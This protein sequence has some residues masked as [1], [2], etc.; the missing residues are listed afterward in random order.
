MLPTINRLLMK[1]ATS[2]SSL[3]QV[4]LG[5]VLLLITT[6]LAGSAKA[7]SI[8]YSTTGLAQANT[9]CTNPLLCGSGVYRGSRA[10]DADLSNY[11]VLY[12]GATSAVS[13]RLGLSGTGEAGSRAGVLLANAGQLLNLQALGAVRVRTYLLSDG[14]LQAQ[15]TRL[16]SPEVV[17]SALLEKDRPTQ[18]EFVAGK[19][20]NQI[21]LEIG[22]LANVSFAVKVFYAYSVPSLVQAQVAGYLSRFPMPADGLYSTAGTDTNLAGAR[23]CLNTEVNNPAAAVDN[24]LSNYASFSSLLTT[25]CPSALTVR[26][27]GRS[28]AGYYAGFVIGNGG[29]LDLSVLSGLRI[30]TWLNGVPQETA[31]GAGLLELHLLPNG[32][33]QV[34]FPTTLPFNEVTIERVGALTALDDLELYYGFGVEPRAFEG[35]TQVLSNFGNPAGQYEVESTALLC[36]GCTVT[37]PENAANSAVG[38]NSYAQIDVPLGVLGEISL[39]L[40]LNGTGQAGN[41]AGMVIGSGTG[42]LDA[43]ALD[44]YTLSTYDAAGNLLESRSGRELLSLNLLA[45]GRQELSFLTT[46]DFA[47]VQLTMTSG[48]SALNSTRVYYAFADDRTGSFPLQ[49]TAPAP[50]PVELTAFSARWVNNKAELNWAT[51]SERASSHFVVERASSRDAAFR[52]VSQVAAA[53]SSTAPQ[54][55]QLRD[56]GALALNAPTLYYRLRQVDTDGLTSFSPVVALAVGKI[57]APELQLYP[58]PATGTDYVTLNYGGL[59]LGGQVQVYSELGRLV[60][61][62][63]VTETA[64]QLPTGPLPGGLYQVVLCD[65]QGQRLAATKLV[66][67]GR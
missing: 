14:V 13:L 47:S 30:R 23:I 27:E 2:T 54:R 26:L 38:A 52:A 22:G 1:P 12:T 50:L 37:N 53:G 4:L 55:Y 44:Q 65:A 57:A 48:I 59:A 17:K 20:Y 51:A 15:E 7:G 28:P 35:T 11:A 61:K 67:A 18:F 36:V 24:D 9:V 10:A 25:G 42:L 41:R 63:P 62:L 60:A 32:Q 49:V 34:S 45:D 66:V 46:R 21:E 16:I 58:N 6:L 29:L 31:T 8:Y 43:S 39:L 56:A 33:G 40:H 19:P 3:S 5:L 64:V